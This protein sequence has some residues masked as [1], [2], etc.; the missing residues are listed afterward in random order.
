ML[1]RTAFSAC[2]AP[3][4][5]SRAGPDRAGP[6]RFS[7]PCRTSRTEPLYYTGCTTPAYRPVC[8]G[9]GL[10]RAGLCRG[11]VPNRP[12][13]ERACTAPSCIA[14]A[15]LHSP[16]PHTRRLLADGV[17]GDEVLR[18]T[19]WVDP[20]LAC[21]NRS[22]RRPKVRL[23]LELFDV[24]RTGDRSPPSGRRCPGTGGQ[25]RSSE[26]TMAYAR[27]AYALGSSRGVGS[28][29]CHAGEPPDMRW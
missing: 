18:S 23:P 28:G 17:E 14:Q 22:Y 20:S 24:A 11:P 29:C 5:P 9:A 26:P 27:R 10:Y 15:V 7:A 2:T 4:V 3:A 21:R 1:Y 6:D 25:N 8:T 19:A 13:S 16:L 12:A